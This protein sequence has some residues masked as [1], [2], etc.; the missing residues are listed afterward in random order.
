M[1]KCPIDFA[2]DAVFAMA[3][4]KHNGLLLAPQLTIDNKLSAIARIGVVRV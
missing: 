2:N 4:G 3:G 1:G